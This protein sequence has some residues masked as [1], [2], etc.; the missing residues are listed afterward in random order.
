MAE[1]VKVSGQR[2]GRLLEERALPRSHV[3]LGQAANR[4][5][6][7]EASVLAMLLQMTLEKLGKAALLRSGGMPV[8]SAKKSHRAALAMVRQLAANK[9]ACRRLGWRTD[10]VQHRVA[11]V[12]QELEHAQPALA[13]KD[14]PCLEYPWE[15]PEGAV[16]RP[17]EHLPLLRWFKAKE[18]D[19]GMMLFRF[20]NDLCTKFDDVFP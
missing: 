8:E 16:Q 2:I 18:G 19:A 7:V 12:V 17:A 1:A 10:V 9:R 15:N 3:P 6:A 5:Q 14:T 4:V 20:T 13:P 11:P